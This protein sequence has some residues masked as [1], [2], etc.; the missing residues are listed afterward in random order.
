MHIYNL[1]SLDLVA[2]LVLVFI[3]LTGQLTIKDLD[4]RIASARLGNDSAPT[5]YDTYAWRCALVALAMI[6]LAIVL[7]FIQ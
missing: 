4:L 3:I 2:I 6:V 5:K 7:T 1:T